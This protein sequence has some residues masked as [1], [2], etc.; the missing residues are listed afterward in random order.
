MKKRLFIALLS[1]T[2]FFVLTSCKK[3]EPVTLIIKTPSIHIRTG[4]TPS[5]S[6]KMETLEFLQAAGN[7][8]EADYNKSLPPKKQIKVIVVGFSPQDETSFVRN[9]FGTPDSPDV[10]YESTFNMSTYINN[11]WVAPIDDL[12]TPAMKSDIRPISFES[13]KVGGKLYGMPF[14]SLQNIIIYNRGL[15]QKAGLERFLP[16]GDTIQSWT[17]SEWREILQT[18]KKNLPADTFPAFMYAKNS[19]G[20]THILTLLRLAGSTV[21][22]DSGNFCLNSEKGIEA[23]SLLKNCYDEG[24]FPPN[25]EALEIEN[26]RKLFELGK[27]CFFIANSQLLRN[28]KTFDYGYVNFPS[29]DCTESVRKGYCTTFDTGFCVF[30]NGDPK[31]LRLAK[32]FVRYIYESN[33]ID[34]SAKGLPCSKK[35]VE[36]YKGEIPMLNE[37]YHNFEN[38]WDYTGGARNWRRVRDEFYKHIQDLFLGYKTPTLIASEIDKTCNTI[39]LAGRASSHPHE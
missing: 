7:A 10:L 29:A 39:L 26:C 4:S 18:L 8:F 21:F 35:V 24:F 30:D 28:Y 17:L 37:F 5:V 9:A 33:F 1:V 22:D 31:K 27:L 2:V 16:E 38:A 11:G 32:E 36:K 34:H 6:Y 25:C 13:Y 20:D 12:V 14:F 23:L 3:E 15:L 19:Q